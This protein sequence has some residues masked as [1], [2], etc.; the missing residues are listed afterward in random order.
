MN[1]INTNTR[2]INY[3]IYANKHKCS[4]IKQRYDIIKDIEAKLTPDFQLTMIKLNK[5]FAQGSKNKALA[6]KLFN[7]CSNIP[8]KA[9]LNRWS[10][11]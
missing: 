11:V 1:I 5:L 4:N 3:E 10:T 7:Q 8:S 2:Q 6:N 9:Q